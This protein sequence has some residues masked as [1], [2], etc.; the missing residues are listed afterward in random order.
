VGALDKGER[1]TPR[2]NTR[3]EKIFQVPTTFGDRISKIRKRSKNKPLL[4]NPE[5]KEI[6]V[7]K[8]FPQGELNPL[9]EIVFSNG[10][11]PRKW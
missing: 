5:R 10:T 7:K 8:R 11:L 6:S 4:K 9:R 2:L 1:R 3:G